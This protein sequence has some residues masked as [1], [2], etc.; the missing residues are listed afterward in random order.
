MGRPG[1]RPALAEYG[2]VRTSVPDDAEQRVQSLPPPEDEPAIVL[3]GSIARGFTWN[4]AAP[5]DCFNGPVSFNDRANA[6][7]GTDA[8]PFHSYGFDD[9]IISD[10]LSTF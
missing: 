4:P 2:D 7:F 8:F 10:N 5:R 9:Q 3:G 6:V 1:R